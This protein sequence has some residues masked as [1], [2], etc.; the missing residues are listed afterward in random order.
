M[1][2]F[3]AP[4]AGLVLAASLLASCSSARTDSGTSADSCYLALPTA[5]QAV[6]HLWGDRL[7]SDN[8][9][10]RPPKTQLQEWAQGRCLALPVYRQVGREGSEHE[11]IC[12]VE[13]KVGTL[14]PAQGRGQTKRDAESAAA[15]LMLEQLSK[16]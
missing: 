5:A 13:V 4:V 1:R 14:A 3:V 12:L 11:P 7:G 16:A 9:A 10:P 15:G 2:R 8:P 6:E